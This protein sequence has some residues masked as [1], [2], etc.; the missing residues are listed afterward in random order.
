MK[1]RYMTEENARQ[2]LAAI[3]DIKA[4]IAQVQRTVDS[5]TD[6]IGRIVRVVAGPMPNAINNIEEALNREKTDF[7]AKVKA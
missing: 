6:Q 2:I 7:F 1:G 5:H 4:D 3:K